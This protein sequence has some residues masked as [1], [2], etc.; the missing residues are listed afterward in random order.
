MFNN[1][2]LL[3]KEELQALVR[4]ECETAIMAAVKECINAQKK[5]ASPKYLNRRE[6]ADML[7]ISTST[8]HRLVN[9]QHLKCR[10]VGRKTLF[11]SSDVE[12]VVLTLNK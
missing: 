11:L 6:A 1:I 5:C 4:S 9:Q 10:K 8:L 7:K 3:G 12:N 2:I